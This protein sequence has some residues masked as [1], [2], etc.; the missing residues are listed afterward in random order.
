MK[1][2]GLLFC[3]MLSF[4]AM[5][6]LQTVALVK[7]D[8]SIPP[9]T[10]IGFPGRLEG[11][12]THFQLNNSQYLNVTVDSSEPI[13]LVLE[14]VPEM[15]MMHIES[16]FN[17]S[18]STIS[19]SGF[20]SL[21]TYHKYED[22]YH[23]HSNFTTDVNGIYTYTQDI[24]VLHLV[25]IQPRA[26][27]IYLSNSGWSTPV[28][29]WDPA[30]KT[31]TLT[32]DVSET[33]EIDGNSINLDGNGH[34]ATGSNT[35]SG[36]YI[37]GAYNQNQN[38]TIKNLKIKQFTYGILLDSSTNNKIYNNTVSD[39]PDTG[40]RLMW[41]SSSTLT[42]NT[43]SNS[44]IGIF[45]YSS[46]ISTLT[47][48]TVSHNYYGIYFIYSGGNILT[49][50]T[51]SYT[52]DGIF[53]HSVSGD[54]TL[55]G[56]TVSYSTYGITLNHYSGNCTLTGNTASYSTYGITLQDYS[57]S[58]TL[59]GNTASNN[60]YGIWLESYSNNN[61][62]YNNNFIN[63][64][65]QAHVDSSSGS[66]F[67]LLAPTGGNYW[68][69]W[70]TPDNNHDGF[71]DY[72]YVFTGGQDNLPWTKQNGWLDNIPP[73]TTISLSGT[74]GS[75]G[76][77][78]SDVQAT[79]TATDN[80]GGTGVKKTEY[81]FDNS[82][83]TTYTASFTI[84]TEG[85][86]IVYYRSTDNNGNTEQTKTKQIEI[87]KTL[88]TITITTPQATTYSTNFVPLIFSVDEPT[89]WIGYSLD[90]GIN[91]TITG[92]TTLTSLSEAT[93]NVVVYANDTAG[94]M[95]KSN[96]VSFNIQLPKAPVANFTW[97]PTAPKVG[98]TVTFDGSSSTP[99]GGTITKYEWDF[100]DSG[101]ATGQVVT[102]AYSSK[103]LY[104]VTLNV[105]DSEG[106]WDI[107]QKQI[108]V[109]QTYTLAI[110]SVPTGIT[111]T[112]DGI[113]HTT[114]WSSV[115]N[116]GA[117]P[118]LV[119]PESYMV[120]VAKYVWDK[121]DDGVTTRS[122]TVTMNTDIS[123]TAKFTGPNYQLT[124]TSTPITGIPFTINSAPNA[125]PYVEWLPEG[126]YTLEMPQT[127]NGY[128][129][130]HWLED[131]D[132][133]RVKTIYLHGTTWTGVYV[134]VSPPTPPVGGEWVPID[135]LQLLPQL[136]SLASLMTALTLS[137][138][139]VRRKRLQD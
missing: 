25:F 36:V 108:Q 86:T 43:V 97:S 37:Y 90:G 47:G 72:P 38:A 31:A 61:K 134:Q 4:L 24:S 21:A 139:Y 84:S 119:M 137:F 91:T 17:V 107:E 116:E 129:W 104:T 71:V 70:T 3:L 66:V 135:K 130:S 57:Y 22:D 128:D 32:Q 133:S 113:S 118:G 74:L 126:Y 62:I 28:G 89:S 110:Y 64:P 39:N 18:S 138:V 49:G 60:Q 26:S 5:F 42:G 23:N 121:W 41:S 44:Y 7:A 9:P 11:S 85:T 14:S 33:I 94:N 68:S 132:P 103:G 87:D 15:I 136:I 111:F 40:I 77:Y 123:L 20:P 102:H 88:P 16:V 127:Y 75:N 83:W 67:N 115:Y 95:G 120:G 13:K 30:T 76:W 80:P 106:L 65:T 12:G 6:A 2:L 100:G 98:E 45:L 35:G 105:T 63:N 99:N 93:H 46:G 69:S 27:T 101:K 52:V 53:L 79:L 55:T 34:T 56:N 82:T 50:N 19:L 54:C 125:T 109:L 112:V 117:M 51:V 48:N 10:D 29:T 92:N 114:S 58:N 96:V 124:V 73:T 131:G 78:I 1:K 122:R 8:K 59:T 81:S